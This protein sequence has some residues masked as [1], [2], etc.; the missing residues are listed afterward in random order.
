MTIYYIVNVKYPWGGTRVATYKKK[1]SNK[2]MQVH[3]Y[4]YPKFVRS[5]Y[6]CIEEVLQEITERHRE[7]YLSH[8]VLTYDEYKVYMTIQELVD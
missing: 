6:R 1:I 4:T 8:R 2:F 7:E 5:G 3:I